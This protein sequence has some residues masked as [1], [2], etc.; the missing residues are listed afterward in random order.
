VITHRFEEIEIGWTFES[1]LLYLTDIWV[2]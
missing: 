1:C 2:V